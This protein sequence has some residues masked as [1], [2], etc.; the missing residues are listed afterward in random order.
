MRCKLVIFAATL[1]ALILFSC[2]SNSGEANPVKTEKSQDKIVRYARHFNIENAGSYR[3]L[4]LFGKKNSRDTTVVYVLYDSLIPPIQF[5]RQ[6]YFIKAPCSSI[7]ALSSIYAAMLVELNALDCLTAIDNIDYINQKD[8]LKKHTAG[9]ILELSKG[10]LPDIEKTVALR[11]D[12]VLMFGM[13]NP[14]EEA[15]PVLHKAGIP[16]AL[17]VDHLEET[18]LARAEWIKFIAAFAGKEQQAEAIFSEV[19]LAYLKLKDSAQHFAKRPKVLSE[20][21]YGETWFVPGGK[22]FMATFIQDAGADYVWKENNS[23]GS[24][25]L[26]FEQAYR[27]GGDADAWINLSMVQNKNEMLAQE[28][29]Y[30]KFKAFELGHLYNNNKR[31]NDKGYS[32]YW[33]TAMFHPDRVLRDFILI[34]HSLE[35]QEKD[36]YYY[37]IIR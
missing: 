36:L 27:K 6:H 22:S 35:V 3:L 15:N 18:P 37:R 17:I 20:L 5:K 32:D 11:P 29:R 10:P 28:K 19:E 1:F 12:M 25:P 4:T 34:F 26:S 24:L 30:Q 14:D 16:V 21:K 33:E 7:A 13:G 31:V 8:I 9:Q 23:M 2:G